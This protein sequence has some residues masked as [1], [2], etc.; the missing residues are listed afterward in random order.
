MLKIYCTSCQILFRLIAWYASSYLK[1]NWAIWLADLRGVYSF[2]RKYKYYYLPRAQ[3]FLLDHSF[4]LIPK[5]KI[6]LKPQNQPKFHWTQ[7]KQT[8]F[9]S[10]LVFGHS[11]KITEMLKSY[12]TG[13]QIWFR[14]NAWYA[15]SSL[16]T[17]W[18][19]LLVNLRGVYSFHRKSKY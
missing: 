7:P 6:N 15:S 14:L 19:I 16:K 10:S 3:T 13:C 9:V 11:H 4:G 5:L 1:I 17:N 18:A 8:R 2:H 12:C